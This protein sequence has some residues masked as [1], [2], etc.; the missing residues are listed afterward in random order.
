MEE[1]GILIGGTMLT[2]YNDI[3][4]CMYKVVPYVTVLISITNYMRFHRHVMTFTYSMHVS[5]NLLSN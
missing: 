5:R 1:L 2:K 3:S 4:K